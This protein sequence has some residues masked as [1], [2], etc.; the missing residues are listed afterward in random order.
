MIETLNKP[1]Y[2]NCQI[3]TL[4]PAAISIFFA[5]RESQPPPFAASGGSCIG[6]SEKETV[7][8]QQ[9]SS[10]EDLTYSM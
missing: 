10:E 9:I 5:L 1:K 3:F 6:V 4:L 2:P 8:W 7:L